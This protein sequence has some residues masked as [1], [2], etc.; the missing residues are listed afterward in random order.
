[1]TIIAATVQLTR[2]FALVWSQSQSF[3]CCV[4]VVVVVGGGGGCGVC[5]ICGGCG[6]SS[7]SSINSRTG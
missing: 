1:M 2:L 6:V 4:I 7:S 3:A 5:R